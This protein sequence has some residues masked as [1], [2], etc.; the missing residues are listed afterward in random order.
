M[1]LLKYE[2]INSYID[3]KIIRAKVALYLNYYKNNI[4][5]FLK[6]WNS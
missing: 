1:T 2:V 6:N 5:R 4:S 3:K